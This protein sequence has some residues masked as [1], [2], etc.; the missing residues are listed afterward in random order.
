MTQ[1][2]GMNGLKSDLIKVGQT[3]VVGKGYQ[4]LKPGLVRVRNLRRSQWRNI[5]G[6]HSGI[7]YGNA[8]IYGKAHRRRG[9]ENGLAYHF[10]IGNGLDSGDG[11]IE[12]GDRWKRQIE[13][14]HVSQ[15]KYNLNSV[16]ICVVGDFEKTAPTKNQMAAFKEL[17]AYL[18][19]DSLYGRPRFLVHKE[20]KNEQTICPGKHFPIR[21]LHKQ[22]G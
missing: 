2:K 14:G 19:Y 13:G 16:G 11:E 8:S 12:I 7:R 9:M 6:H 10:V 17:V 20:V 21:E 22:F 5:I 4:F 15:R 1:L 3:L 18:K